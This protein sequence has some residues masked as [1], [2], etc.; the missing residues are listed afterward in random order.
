MDF[1]DAVE[2]LNLL[3]MN[4]NEKVVALLLVSTRCPHCHKLQSLLQE[5][6]EKGLLTELEIINVENTPD[7]AQHYGVRSV[8]W[9]RLGSF[10]FDEVIT[11]AELDRWIEQVKA[12]T[13]ESHYINYL[14]EHG[15]LARAIEWI[16]HEN[17]ALNTVIPLLTDETTKINVR[18]G[19]GAILEHFAGTPAI[20]AI[21]PD[22][23]VLLQNSNHTVRTDA[24]Y[25]LSL[26]H[27]PDVIESLQKLLEHEENVQVRQV[28]ME[29][30]EELTHS[31]PE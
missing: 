27:S 5:R 31:F 12:G 15:K 6:M 11:P 9:L 20:K 10:V 7:V 3:V 17:V 16:E 8:P 1:L 14:L 30:I 4:T 21:I 19:I 23:S 13:G 28:A 22:L 25:Y 26:T 24:C 2:G 18:I 29:S